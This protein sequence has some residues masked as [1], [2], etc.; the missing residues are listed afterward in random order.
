MGEG[1]GYLYCSHCGTKNE[2]DAQYCIA[3][4]YSLSKPAKYGTLVSG[5]QPYCSSCGTKHS[6]LALY[7]MECGASIDTYSPIIEEETTFESND[8]K[9]F[10]DINLLKKVAP[11]VLLSTG[12]LFLMSILFTSFIKENYLFRVMR[13]MIPGMSYPGMS[14]QE[15]IETVQQFNIIEFLLFSSFTNI[16]FGVTDSAMQM[17]G[18]Y[19]SRILTSIIIFGSVP[20]V[21]LLAGGYFIKKRNPELVQ[22]GAWKIA[23]FFAI[24]YGL[25]LG[26]L[27]F[28][29]GVS[30]T[31]D[32]TSDGGNVTVDQEI[33]MTMRYSFISAVVNGI[34]FGFIFSYL[35]II[36]GKNNL[37]SPKLEKPLNSLTTSLNYS[38][39]AYSIGYVVLLLFS[40]I[41]VS[42]LQENL[43]EYMFNELTNGSTFAFVGL[44]FQIAVYFF[45][46]VT[47]NSFVTNDYFHFRFLGTDPH[48]N[49]PAEGNSMDMFFADYRPL[50]YAAIVVIALLFIFIGR[51]LANSTQKL[52]LTIGIYS[53][54]FAVIMTF[55]TYHASLGMITN[56]GSGM[57]SI[58]IMIGFD[59]IRAFIY[60]LLYAGITA[61]IGAKTRKF[62]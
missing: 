45:N 16:T 13:D 5:Y 34:F 44:V 47:F 29:T 2:D 41:Y 30:I 62:F 7:C 26:V 3:D 22:H 59:P 39:F 20:V 40:Y 21:S 27:T 12:L 31:P 19:D 57:K 43:D 4:G 18:G 32:L 61:F 38:F 37:R 36:M 60:S 6:N 10:F 8:Y 58:N 25:I 14:G 48:F 56:Q 23:A 1:E 49:D 54:V 24:C 15:V 42:Q 53:V 50:Y 51:L 55:L 28:L 33:T 52:A 35:G 9:Q 46:F 11:G 17:G